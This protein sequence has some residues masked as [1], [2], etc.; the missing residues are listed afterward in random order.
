MS[1]EQAQSISILMQN[2]SLRENKL[3]T[4]CQSSTTF[5]ADV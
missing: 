3:S 2:I 4:S 5:T 1:R